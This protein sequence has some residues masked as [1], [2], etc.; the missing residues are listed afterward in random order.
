[1][2]EASLERPS[3]HRAATP[4]AAT[5]DVVCRALTDREYQIASYK[6]NALLLQQWGY[7]LLPVAPAAK[8]EPAK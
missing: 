7:V 2:T 6:L 1:M 3:R 8:F 5:T 4:T